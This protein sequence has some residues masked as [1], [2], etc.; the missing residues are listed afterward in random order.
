VAAGSPWTILEAVSALFPAFKQLAFDDLKIDGDFICDLGG[1]KTDQLV[2]DAVVGIA[3][4]L[5]KRT[6][7]EFVD[8]LRS[9]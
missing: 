5:G 9:D 3:E 8:D 7:A 2:I 4:G 1:N 6:V